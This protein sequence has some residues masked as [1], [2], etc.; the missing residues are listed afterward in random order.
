[1]FRVRAGA[2]AIH[3]AFSE[4]AK[5]KTP[6][7]PP[8]TPAA[9]KASNRTKNSMVLKWSVSSYCPTT[10]VLI[11]SHLSLYCLSVVV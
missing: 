5:F 8:S 1:M 4:I 2:N 7:C 11:M 3:G 6:S 10:A 9:P